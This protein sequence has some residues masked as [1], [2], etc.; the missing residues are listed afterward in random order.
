MKYRWKIMSVPENENVSI[1]VNIVF[2][3]WV[4]IGLEITL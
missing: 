4:C 3:I 1:Q 2:N